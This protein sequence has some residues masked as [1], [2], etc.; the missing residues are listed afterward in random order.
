M[1]RFN[2][3]LAQIVPVLFGHVLFVHV[4][5]IVPIVLISQLFID[6][7]L[8]QEEDEFRSGVDV[9]YRLGNGSAV[10]SVASTINR[11]SD[12]NAV[13]IQWDGLLFAQGT[14]EYQFAAKLSGSVRVEV[15]GEILL[16]GNS[17][18]PQW[19]AGE[20][21]KLNFSRHPFKVIHE[22]KAGTQLVL[23][24]RGPTH[25]WEPIGARWLFRADGS[26]V[27]ESVV[28]GARIAK[29]HRC[30]ACHNGVSK[31]PSAPSLTG[32]RGN[33]RP[34]WLVQRLTDDGV[35][36]DSE[37]D[38]R[39]MPFFGMPKDEA[40]AIAAY[41]FSNSK[42]AKSPKQL[43]K[44]DVARGRQT[45]LTIGCLACHSATG[46][47]QPN[48]FG[49]GPLDRVT[50]K[51]TVDFFARWLTNPASV[52]ANHRMPTFELTRLEKADVIS[53]LRTLSKAPEPSPAGDKVENETM[54]AKGKSLFAK[55]RCG[56]CHDS[57]L[58]KE[59]LLP[60]RTLN[61]SNAEKLENGCGGN[62]TD[63]HPGFQFDGSQ[64]SALLSFLGKKNVDAS[65]F[66]NFEDKLAESNCLACH[67][68]GTSRGLHDVALQVVKQFPKLA[69]AAL[70][71]PSLDS[72]GDK[73]NDKAL[74][75]AIKREEPT[76]RP[77]LKIRMPKFPLDEHHRGE[78]VQLL[79]DADR[80][81]EGEHTLK[82]TSV[83]AA[84]VFGARLVTTDGFGCTS[85]HAVGATKP[86]K[87][88]LN[89][90]GPDLAGMGQRIRYSW[91]RRWVH[92]PA[93]IVPQMEMPSVRLP[94]KGLLNDELE[95]QLSAVWNV[96]NRPGFTPPE[97]NPLRVLRQSGTQLKS[98]GI[99][100]TDV[101]QAEGKTWIKP[102][103]IGLAN[104]HNFF[105]DLESGGLIRW[106]TGDLARQR[107]KG[108]TWF[109]EAA[110]KNLFRLE[111]TQPEL[112]VFAADTNEVTPHRGGQFITEI[113]E[114]EHI[115]SGVQ[116]THRLGF[117]TA[118][119]V[120]FV[121]MKQT[122]QSINGQPWT[123]VRRTIELDGLDRF[124]LAKFAV[125]PLGNK[126]RAVD[127]GRSI[128]LPGDFPIVVRIANTSYKI[129]ATGSVSLKPTGKPIRIVLDYVSTLPVDQFHVEVP[130]APQP[131]Q[132]QLST[133]P[134]F[135]ATRAPIIDE[136][137]P[138]GLA[139]RDNGDLIVTSLK[140]RVWIARDTNGDGIEDT[141][142]V[143]S[144][145]L[146]A[147][148]G[149]AAGKN[150]IDVINKY[151]LLRLYDNDGDGHA[152]KMVRLASGWGHTADYHD[153][154]V[155]LPQD[156]KG[157]YYASFACQQDDR[158]AAAAKLRG[159]VVQLAPIK[160]KTGVDSFA[161]KQLTAGHRFPIG[162]ARN[163]QGQLYVTD[164][165]GNY[166][167]FNELNRI[168]A[169]RRYGFINKIDRKPN[170]TPPFM[171]PSIDIPHPWT[172]SVNGICFLDSPNVAGK[173]ASIFGP[174]EGH[175]VGCEYDTRR[176]IRMSLQKVGDVVQGA[177][178]PMSIDKPNGE[179]F[180]GPITCAVSP[181]GALYVGCIRDSG[182]GGA[183]NIG[184]VVKLEPEWKQLPAGI[185]EVRH[186]HGGFEIEFTKPV[187]AQLGGDVNNYAVTSYTRVSTPAYGGKD[188]QS[189]SESI[190]KLE[191]NAAKN[192]VR[193][194]LKDL[195]PN[196]VY[197]FH[198]KS[199][200][201]EGS[202]FFPADAFYTLRNVEQR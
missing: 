91:Y 172:R 81:P 161:I 48:D 152:E 138:T 117:K 144:D 73:L 98:R 52:I 64:Q 46:I 106:S 65:Y 200:V 153:W 164:N 115:S 173:Q 41:V 33:L 83:A 5:L 158:T 87:A 15:D 188:E 168:V 77:W 199:L 202:Q 109:W 12:S 86:V 196:F 89:A 20:A 141:T 69:I 95:D 197:E 183:N 67:Q 18:S 57:Q 51:R 148:F 135:K 112:S 76:R 147:P 131:D 123:G 113:D 166:N 134:G 121:R 165:Q 11:P 22:G 105:Y 120:K 39:K 3:R 119:E 171:A 160:G 85:C 182:W 13:A 174:F 101:T 103:M 104:R 26:Q 78:L 40:Q 43:P 126:A 191:L 38:E 31:P 74:H 128:T 143:Y 118:G 149:A 29:T 7:A 125:L 24:W 187:N 177:A 23:Y 132:A 62:P 72:V 71:S 75:V 189:R 6:T 21:T 185:A 129:D 193:L 145:E 37:N 175:L 156:S 99:V 122:F 130:P 25:Q 59:Q 70:K 195:R 186:I 94:V 162:I 45:V 150:Y 68:R 136:W 60:T 84:D 133:V 49:G 137:M 44:G 50:E 170:F 167:P 111:S 32:V 35:H 180:L 61:V 36:A 169:G 163:K 102:L 55:H 92:N 159:T 58:H 201:A 34:A 1:F 176:L 108:K 194:S 88:P 157:N 181:T 97:P 4:V 139:W 100:Q 93:R 114:L 116:L 30:G 42:S 16:Q 142:S 198:L 192:S 178:Y 190:V 184:T 124:A 14:G 110:G 54:I 19:I 80:V 90:L 82:P 155:G 140:G 2:N 151:G 28:V 107:T 63:S 154:A 17:D 10:Q 9:T 79:I 179:P 127:S 56:S 53:F 47:G 96:L 66:E 8:A 146:A 27:D